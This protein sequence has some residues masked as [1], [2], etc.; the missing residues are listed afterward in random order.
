MCFYI[1]TWSERFFYILDRHLGDETLAG[2]KLGRDCLRM[3]VCQH[4]TR[5]INLQLLLIKL[6]L[7]DML[8]CEYSKSA[9][10]TVL[11]STV[12]AGTVCSRFRNSYSFKKVARTFHDF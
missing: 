9:G 5:E 10:G 1:S 8:R 3:L 7:L 4:P 2:E 6:L 11:A 12:F